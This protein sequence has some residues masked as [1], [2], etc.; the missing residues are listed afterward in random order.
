[1]SK[2]KNG[3]KG[4][5]LKWIIIVILVLGVIIAVAGS[6]GDGDKTEQVSDG[7]VEKSVAKKDN[8]KEEES[9]NKEKDEAEKKEDFKE[10]VVVDNDE[11]SI[12]ITG[13]E[14]DNLWGYTLNVDLENKSSEKNYTFSVL[15]AAINGVQTDPL[16]ATDVSAGKKSNSEINFSDSSL[17]EYGIEEFTDIEIS[18]RVYDSDNWEAD[19]VAKETVHVY[20]LGEENVVKFERESKDS[21]VV[22][23]DNDEVRATIIGYRNDEIWGYTADIFL[24]NKTDKTIMFS[25]EDV[26]VNGYMSDPLWATSVSGGKCAFSS[27]SWSSES[28]EENGIEEVK[29]I[30]FVFNAYDEESMEDYFKEKI[31]LKP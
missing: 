25:V 30:E 15:D 22:I 5:K 28:L 3:K 12:K 18:F 4:G 10:I 27:M 17:K 21:D 13:I 23:V 9:E 16:F 20:P 29:E 31:T 6:G 14:P 1:M 2:E 8:K 19:D 24:Q 11:C 26:S 7:T